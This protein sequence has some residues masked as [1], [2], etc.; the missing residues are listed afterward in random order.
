[1]TT[2]MPQTKDA[3]F[4]P[5][6]HSGTPGQFATALVLPQTKHPVIL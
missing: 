2:W 4:H 3:L 5:A 1:M 6:L